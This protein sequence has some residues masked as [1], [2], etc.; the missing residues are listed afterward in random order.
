MCLSFL[1]YLRNI[2]FPIKE[3]PFEN[4]PQEITIDILSRL[5]IQTTLGCKSVCKPWHDL[6]EGSEFITSHLSKSSSTSNNS[7]IAFV[8][9]MDSSKPYKI[10]AFDDKGSS[11]TLVSQFG[12]PPRFKRLNAPRSSHHGF[13]L[14]WARSPY[15]IVICNPITREY[16]EL[17]SPPRYDKWS[18]FGF[19]TSKVSGKYKVVLISKKYMSSEPIYEVHTLGTD[20]W[21]SI[22]NPNPSPKPYGNGIA[23]NG[24]LHWLASHSYDFLFKYNYN[25]NDHNS[26]ICCFDLETEVFSSFSTPATFGRLSALEGRLCLCVYTDG[27]RDEV[28]MWLMNSYG[29]ANSWEKKLIVKVPP[30]I[31][32]GY[33]FPIKVFKDGGGD[34]LFVKESSGTLFLYSNKTKTIQEYGDHIRLCSSCLSEVVVYTPTFLSLE[35]ICIRD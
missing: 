11:T 7:C 35:T 17:P 21:R 8:E 26:F 28:C 15:Q 23:L 5:P 29:D 2:L 3:N 24:N 9:E 33:F 18:V 4:L 31:S 1:Q 34:V 22:E 12:F 32:F 20:S 10:Y 30:F 19:G 27:H 25:Y 14:F 13:I 16:K 6:M